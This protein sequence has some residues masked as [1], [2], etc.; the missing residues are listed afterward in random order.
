MAYLEKR[1]QSVGNAE[2]LAVKRQGYHSCSE[3]Y[4]HG[5]DTVLDRGPAVK[6]SSGV[7][8]RPSGERGT[9]VFKNHEPSDEGEEGEEDDEDSE[10][11]EEEDSE[12]AE[13]GIPE[14]VSD[15]VGF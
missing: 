8:A 15:D 10:E 2:V 11:E 4:S 7:T 12:E 14:D 13:D 6:D 3:G 1:T 9:T 5:T